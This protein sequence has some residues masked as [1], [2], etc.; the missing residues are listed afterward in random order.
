ME[1]D[2]IPLNVQHLIEKV[3]NEIGF[4]LALHDCY[5]VHLCRHLR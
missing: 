5:L 4:K 2:V 1:N 3:S